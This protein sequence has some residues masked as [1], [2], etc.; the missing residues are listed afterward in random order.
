[1]NKNPKQ[2]RRTAQFEKKLAA[3]SLAG[4]AALIAPAAAKASIVYD[5]VDTVVNY[6]NSYGFFLTGSALPDISINAN[7]GAI[8]ASTNN[9]AEVSLDPTFSEDVAA[10]GF[11]AIIDPSSSN[12]GT[13]GKMAEFPFGDWSTTGGTAYLGFEFGNPLDPQA[14]WAEISTTTTSTGSSFE[15]LSYAYQ[16]VGGTPIS[17][18]EGSPVPEPSALSLLAL[19]GVGLIALRR[20]RAANA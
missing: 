8:S 11:G 1:M 2:P 12:W 18:G 14:G 4:A 6:P 13:G 10:L 9:S 5:S 20:R 19:G 16:T 7:D 15:I 17:A 3:Y